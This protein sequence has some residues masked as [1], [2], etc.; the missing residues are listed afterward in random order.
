MSDVAL[1]LS[2]FTPRGLE[3]F[4][5]W[6]DYGGKGLVPL[7]LLADASFATQLEGGVGV[8]PQ[9]FASRYD[10]GGYLAGVLMP[11]GAHA[12][13]YDR[14]LW[15]WLAAAF[16]EHISPRDASGQR[17][18]RRPY[19]YILED[20]RKYYRHLVRTPW[21][22]VATHG[23]RCRY[24]LLPEAG[25][26]A[27]LSRQRKLLETLASRQSLIASPTLLDAACKLYV[28]ART[29]A[30]KRGFSSE[31]GGSPRRLALIANQ[32]SLT[33]D[34]HN[35]PVDRFLELLPEEFGVR[36]TVRP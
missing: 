19:A 6:I 28:D 8:V 18:L 23:E 17:H 30:P 27:P 22:L 20:S 26:E 35:M 32:L 13:A 33:H 34:I 4:A 9:P 16:F 7:D 10:F 5:K 12:I 2:R 14:G 1:N 3:E 15:S 24:L 21:Y 11:L 29:G 31:R 36:R 25:D